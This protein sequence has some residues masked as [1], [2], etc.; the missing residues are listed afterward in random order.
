MA[1]ILAPKN[2]E[3]SKKASFQKLGTSSERPSTICTPG[4]LTF[5]K[6]GIEQISGKNNSFSQ[7]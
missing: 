7:V 1:R 2:D 4:F 5:K 6:D 3:T